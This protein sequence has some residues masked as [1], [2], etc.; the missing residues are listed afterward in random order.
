[1]IVLIVIVIGTA[2]EPLRCVVISFSFNFE[3]V[4]LSR[5]Q[6]SCQTVKGSLG[7]AQTIKTSKVD[8]WFG[9]IGNQDGNRRKGTGF[10]PIEPY[11]GCNP[12]CFDYERN[13][14]RGS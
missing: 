9:L 7:F 11:F 2:K 4:K 6:F 8:R 13:T 10:I 12:D 1:M 3:T 5:I 14:M